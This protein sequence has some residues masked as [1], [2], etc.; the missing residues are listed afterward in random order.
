MAIPRIAP[1]NKIYVRETSGRATRRRWICVWLTQ[2]VYAGLPWL[3]WNGRPAVLFDLPARTF[4]VFGLVLWPQ[5]LIYLTGVL[6]F[7]AVLLFL[8]SALAGRVWCSLGCPHSVYTEIFMWIEHRIEGSRAARMRRDAEPLRPQN[9][10]RKCVK[11]A[12]WIAVS[13]WIGATLVAYFTPVH[14]L[15]QQIG[16]F[17][18]GPWQIFWIL[19]YAALAYVNAGW[20]REQI[21]QQL[22]AYARFQSA[23]CDRDTFMIT[24][25]AQR[26][27]PRARRGNRRLVSGQRGACVDC[28]LCVQVCPA[29]IDVR[30]GHQFACIDC[31]ACIDACDA[32]MKKIGEQPGLIRYV[33]G[34]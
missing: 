23:L 26:G 30:Q 22:C 8:L 31:G 6:I 2:A 34:G 19:A 10:A 7:C 1:R 11:H 15:M 4:H 3:S 16:S 14:L 32:V 24:Y 9:L 20:M 27:E 13:L 33:A 29:G 28:T 18:L 5:D 21:C 17:T 25:D 12:A